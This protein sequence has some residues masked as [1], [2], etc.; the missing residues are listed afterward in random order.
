MSDNELNQ[1]YE[2]IKK[3]DC[4][5]FFNLTKNNRLGSMM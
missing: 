1:L 4:E 5:T 3:D 2:A